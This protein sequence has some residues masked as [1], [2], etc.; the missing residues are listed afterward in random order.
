MSETREL[1]KD[2]E[3]GEVITISRKWR[4]PNCDNPLGGVNVTR[5]PDG[6]LYGR[7]GISSNVPGIF[8]SFFDL[9]A[10]ELPECIS[11][12]APADPAHFLQEEV[13]TWQA[14]TFPGSEIP[15]KI[16]HLK[17]EVV[18]L[19]QSITA[20]GIAQES[21]DCLLLLYGIASLGGFNLEYETWKKLQ[22]NR[23]RTW[24]EADADGVVEHIDEDVS[25]RGPGAG[26]VEPLEGPL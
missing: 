2:M 7:K 5:V 19:D 6:I 10:V 8:V 18:E 12:V 9:E 26:D 15:S 3:I 21:A 1:Y 16:A 4:D 11:S 17:K 23:R 14:E 24:G 20:E 13:A 22:I 25:L